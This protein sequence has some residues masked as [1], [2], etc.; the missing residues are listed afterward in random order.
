MVFQPYTREQ[1][2]QIVAARLEGLDVFEPNAIAFA[3]AKV[4]L[5]PIPYTLYPDPNNA[6]M[7]CTYRPEDALGRRLVA[8]YCCVVKTWA[9]HD[10]GDE[11]PIH[12]SR[13]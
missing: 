4:S 8:H 10:L 2:S 11:H 3:A 12:L 13:G 6:T 5:Y 1:L 9:P 7:S